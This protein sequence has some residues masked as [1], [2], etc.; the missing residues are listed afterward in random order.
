[1]AFES[2]VGLAPADDTTFGAAFGASAAGAGAGASLGSL[3]SAAAFFVAFLA[4]GGFLVEMTPSVAE[5]ALS[6][7]ASSS[8]LGSRMRPSRSALRRRRSACA[9]TTLEE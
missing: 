7:L 8:T 5:S 3:G 6:A 2:G 9:S 4:G 1:M